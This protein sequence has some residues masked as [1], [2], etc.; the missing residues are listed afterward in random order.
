MARAGHLPAVIQLFGRWGSSA[1]F[2]YVRDALLGEKGGTIAKKTEQLAMLDQADI[3]AQL[4]KGFGQRIADTNGAVMTAVEAA[5]ERIYEK[6]LPRLLGQV[7]DVQEVTDRVFA[8]VEEQINQLQQD[9]GAISGCAVPQYVRVLDEGRKC[10]RTWGQDV[11][12]C[13]WNW[14]AGGAVP[15]P[16]SEWQAGAERCRKCLRRTGVRT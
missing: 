13:G 15:V 3:T 10:H 14:A 12:L 2:G 8:L 11:T 1:V 6:L 7:P 16:A 5:A 9:I 4:E